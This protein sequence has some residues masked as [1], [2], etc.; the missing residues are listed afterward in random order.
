MGCTGKVK[1]MNTQIPSYAI[2]MNKMNADLTGFMRSRKA[3]I[4]LPIKRDEFLN[5]GAIE[6]TVGYDKEN[7]MNTFTRAEIVQGL[8]SAVGRAR[9]YGPKK[10][11]QS[12]PAEPNNVGIK[13]VLGLSHVVGGKGP[14][15]GKRVPAL[16]HCLAAARRK[17]RNEAKTEATANA[18]SLAQKLGTAVGFVTTTGRGKNKVVTLSEPFPDIKSAVRGYC[19]A[20]WT[21]SW[22]ETTPDMK[23]ARKAEAMNNISNYNELK[24]KHS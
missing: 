21:S 20:K 5:D 12:L 13:N 7:T 11:V 22:W 2:Q 23:A 18:L 10:V 24:K 8:T 9:Q 1:E 16:F 17:I 15:A 14:N 4:D 19:R 6:W 3:K